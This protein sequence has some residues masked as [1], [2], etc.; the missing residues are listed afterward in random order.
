MLKTIITKLCAYLG[1]TQGFEYD[2]L[3]ENCGLTDHEI[4]TI[5]E[6]VE[7][8]MTFETFLHDLP[9]LMNGEERSYWHFTVKRDHTTISIYW[10]DKLVI[11][12]DGIYEAT[13]VLRAMYK[14]YKVEFEQ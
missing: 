9:L 2:D 14:M 3:K 11:I 6:I 4:E 8:N 13:T 7:D 5:K 12:A 1:D 10:R